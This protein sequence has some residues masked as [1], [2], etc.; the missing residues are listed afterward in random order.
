MAEECLQIL[1]SV[2]LDQ[3]ELLQTMI[4]GSSNSGKVEIALKYYERLL[5][6]SQNGI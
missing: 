3:I 4:V 2:G 1:V 5:S 6:I